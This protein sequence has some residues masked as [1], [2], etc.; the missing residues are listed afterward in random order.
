MDDHFDHAKTAGDLLSG[1][2]A[3]GALIQYLPQVAAAASLLW[4]I[5]RIVE[6]AVLKFSPRDH[7]RK[8]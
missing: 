4:S 5:I 7:E 3:L 8:S 2:A 1:V 6:W